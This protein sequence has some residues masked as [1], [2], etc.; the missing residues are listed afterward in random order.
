MEHPLELTKNHKTF[1]YNTLVGLL[2]HDNR[3]TEQRRAD[4]RKVGIIE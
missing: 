2:Y 1:L 3:Q 4:G